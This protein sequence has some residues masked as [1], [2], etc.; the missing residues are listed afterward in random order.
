MDYNARPG[1]P[2]KRGLLDLVNMQETISTVRQRRPFT[3]LGALIALIT[4]AAF[5]FVA[6]RTSGSSPV[7]IPPGS[8]VAVLVAAR[9]LHARV[10][11]N[12]NDVEIARWPAN[13]V[14]PGTFSKLGD[15]LDV[16][17]NGKPKADAQPK[18][19]ALIEIKQGQPLLA[20]E[21]VSTAGETAN[22][23]PA[24]LNIPQ[25]FVA[26]TIPTGEQ[27]GVAG[28]I[29]P[30]DYIGIIATLDSQSGTA[31]RTVLHNV[32]VIRVGAAS[33]TVT[34]GRL[35]PLV[36]AS[37]QSGASTSL[38]V[39]VN[40]C[41]AEYLN[42]FLSR[43]TLRYVLESYND[44]NSGIGA[45]APPG[46]NCTISSTKGVTAADISARYSLRLNP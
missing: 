25:G 41:D 37:G 34:Q 18:A 28:Y 17:S 43:A 19:Y 9:D 44:Y 5:A 2:G 16:D 40:E 26:M 32:H 22:V 14:A 15:V 1:A 35:G 11:L 4:L 27:Q 20:N 36:V 30:G 8:T 12:A 45:S 24:F 33:Y 31:T 29:Q 21:F 13:A 7:V 42:W 3:I 6:T 10:G 39:V 23:A 38:T 46:S